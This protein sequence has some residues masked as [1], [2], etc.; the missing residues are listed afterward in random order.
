VAHPST[1]AA[2]RQVRRQLITQRLASAGSWGRCFCGL[3]GTF[4]SPGACYVCKAYRLNPR[5][6]G[7]LAKTRI[8]PEPNRE[9]DYDYSGVVQRAWRAGGGVRTTEWGISLRGAGRFRLWQAEVEW[10]SLDPACAGDH[11]ETLAPMNAPTSQLTLST[12]WTTSRQPW[13]RRVAAPSL[14]CGVDA[15]DREKDLRPGR[16]PG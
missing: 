9:D 15:H 7:A 16:G 13:T 10:S 1:R 11:P 14:D 4:G 3:Y 2:R 5:F 8:S 6:R 12:D